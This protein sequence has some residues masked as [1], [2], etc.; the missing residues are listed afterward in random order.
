MP[1]KIGRYRTLAELGRG[2]MGCV[3]LAHDPNIERRVALKV[4]DTSTQ[5]GAKAE[6]EL[7]K[8][9]VLEARAAGRLNHA[10]IVA[11]H[12]AGADPDQR[13]AF[14]AMEWIDGQ[15][16][17][18][19]LEARGRLPTEAAAELVA[20]VA[21]ALGYAHAKGVV[22]RDVK[23]ANILIGQDGRWWTSESRSSAPRAIP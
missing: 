4:L 20:Q 16:L 6:A 3:Y 7:Q 8:R 9:F 23:P 15:S 1:E 14:I 19:I 10:G 12:D 22:H 17:A 13:L 18:H 2:T 11:V 5:A 21:D